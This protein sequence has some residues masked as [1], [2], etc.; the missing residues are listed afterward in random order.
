MDGADTLMG[1]GG[2]DWLEGGAGNDSLNGGDGLDVVLGGLGNDTL[3]G[4][5]GTDVLRGGKGND[6]YIVNNGGGIDVIADP[7][8]G[9]LWIEG[10]GNTPPAGI[11]VADGLWRSQDG[12]VSYT[13]TTADA[14]KTSLVVTFASTGA[15][16][17]GSVVL[18]DW[19]P[20][21]LGINLDSTV[22]TQ[23]GAQIF[24]GDQRAK[25]IGVEVDTDIVPGKPGYRDYKWSATSWAAGG[26]LTE[27]VAAIGFSD[28]IEG[29]ASNDLISGLAGNDAL[30]GQG[31]ND[32]IEG[33][34]GADLIGGGAGSDT[35]LG[36]VGN[37]CILSGAGLTVNRQVNVDDPAWAS[38]DG[39]P[40][41][42]SGA[43]WGITKSPAEV[44]QIYGGDQNHDNSPDIV[45]G[46]AGDDLVAGGYGDDFIDGGLDNDVLFGTG[47]ADVVYGNIGDDHIFGDGTLVPGL[48]NTTPEAEHGSDMLDGG[49]GN[50]K[51]YGGGKGDVLFGGADADM[52]FG[53]DSAGELPGASHGEDYL[54]GGTGNDTLDGGGAGDVLLGG[55]DADVMLGDSPDL[56]ETFHGGDVLEGGAGNDALYGFG[57]DDTLRGGIGNDWIAGE[58]Q[59]SSA[60]SSNF[61]GNDYLDGGDGDDTLVGGNGSDTI[62]GGSGYDHLWGGAGDD[63]YII[64]VE[65]VPSNNTPAVQGGIA[66]R[67][68]FVNLNTTN[69]VPV[70]W[71]ASVDIV[72]TGA[73][74]LS[75]SIAAAT[76]KAYS[77]MANATSSVM[78]TATA[79]P[80]ESINDSAGH[81]TLQING[82][83][84]VSD[85]DNNA[86]LTL[87]I[88]GTASGRLLTLDNA[89]Y[90]RVAD[91]VVDGSTVSVRDW[92]QDKVKTNFEFTTQNTNGTPGPDH[93]LFGAGGNDILYGSGLPADSA[94]AYLANDTLDGGFGNDFIFSYD[95]DDFLIGAEGN[96]SLNGDKGNDS[97]WG[98]DGNDSLIDRAGNNVFNGG[99]GDD[100]IDASVYNSASQGSNTIEFGYGD[101]HDLLRRANI[102][103]TTNNTLALGAG[104]SPSDL[105]VT[106]ERRSYWDDTGTYTSGYVDLRISLRSTG[107]SILIEDFSRQN[108]PYGVG[109]PL[110]GVIF[111]DGLIWDT[112]SLC[113]AIGNGTDFND[114]IFGF[115]WDQSLSGGLGDDALVGA[116]PLG[117]DTLSGGAGKD[118]LSGDGILQGGDGDDHVQGTGSLYG[119]DGNDTV[120]KQSW[121]AF[122]SR[123]SIL[124]GGA[125]NDTI[126]GAAGDTL[127]GGLGDDLLQG[128][129]SGNSNS[130]SFRGGAGVDSIRGYLQNTVYFDR[131]DGLDIFYGMSSGATTDPTTWSHLV[132]GSGVLASDVKARIAGVADLV[133]DLGYGDQVTLEGY[134]DEIATSIGD[135]EF[136][137]G[138]SRLVSSFITS[139]TA[140]ADSMTGTTGDDLIFGV[141]GNDT[142]SGSNGND[143][144][145]GGAGNDSLVGGAGNDTL[146]GGV[147]AD[148]LSGGL[149]DDVYHID[150]QDSVVVENLNEGVDSVYI[151]QSNYFQSTYTLPSNIENLVLT[152]FSGYSYWLAGSGNALNNVIT[153][154]GADNTLLGMAGADTLIGDLGNDTLDGGAGIDS[155]VGGSGDDT[156]VVDSVSDVI[157]ELASDGFDQ[158]Q[159]TASYVLGTEVEGLTLLGTTAINGTGNGLGNTLTGNTAVNVLSGLAGNDT[160]D[161]AGGADTLLGGLGDDT[162]VVDTAGTVITEAMSEGIDTI[163][164]SISLVATADNVENVTLTGAGAINATGNDLANVLQG[165]TFANV[166][167]G[168]RGS[169]YMAG[170]AGNDTFVLNKGDG[171]DTIDAS[172]VLT[173]VDTLSV[174]VLDTELVGLRLGDS[175]QLRIK[176]TTDQITVANYFGASYTDASGSAADGKIDRIQFSNGVVWD[177]AAIQL[178]IDNAASNH[179]PVV[180]GTLPALTANQGRV[181][182]YTVVANVVT[183]PDVGDAIVYSVKMGDGSAV[184]SWLAFDSSTRVLSGTPGAVDV[185]TLN[186]VLWGTDSYGLSVSTPVTMSVVV[187]PNAAP[188]LAAAL[189]DQLALEGQAFSY[190]VSGSAFTDPDVGDSL[191]YTAK[192]ADGT[193]LPAWL[194]FNAASHTFTGTPPVGSSG[195]VSVSVTATDTGS[196]SASDIFDITISSANLNLTGT[197]AADTLTGG[198]G[199]DT[200]SGLAGND[201]LTGQAGNDSLDGGLGNDAMAGGLGD[202]TYVVDATTDVVTENANEG[203]DTVQTS[204][205]LTALAANVENLSLLGTAALNATG[206]A[207]NNVLTGNSAA[208]TL[209]GGA[210]NDTMLGGQGND[211]YVVD[212][213]GDV[214]TENLG[215]GTDTIQASVTLATLAANVENLT[216]TGT[217][218]INGVGN[219]LNNLITGNSAINTLTGGAGDDSL[220]GGAGNDNL[221]GGLGNDVYVVDAAGDVVIEN[222]NEGTDTVQSTVT[223]TA[224]AANAENLTLTGTKAINGT[225]N[226]LNNVLIGNSAI[227]TLTG[228]AGD[229]TLDG[230]AGADKLVGGLGNDTY[231]VDATTDVVTE[232]ANEGTDTIQAKVTLTALANNV[233]NLTLLG[234]AALNATGNTLNNLL[235]GNS[236]VNTLTGNAGDDT[237]V[238][239]LGNDVLVGGAGNDTYRFAIGDGQ[240]SVTENDATAGNQD[241]LEFGAGITA[242]SVTVS[243]VT[244]NLVITAKVGTDKVT[245]TNWYL[246]TAYKVENVRWGDGTTTTA[247]QL[248]AAAAG[249]GLLAVVSPLAS[250]M[251]GIAPVSR[252]KAAY[253]TVQRSL[254]GERGS[255]VDG[256]TEPTLV[257]PAGLLSPALVA[258]HGLN[259]R[260]AQMAENGVLFEDQGSS[261]NANLFDSVTSAAMG[262]GDEPYMVHRGTWAGRAMSQQMRAAQP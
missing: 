195:K 120:R 1:N 46:G 154:N 170:G 78:V 149:G 16:K 235:T 143:A 249:T 135:V 197:A 31:G 37:D 183:D 87:E 76:S 45:D 196:L 28:V 159:A 157:L 104:I 75:Q 52:L 202:D 114:N 258:W 69:T 81:D 85:T 134:F 12:K 71:N 180:S 25:I 215:E 155:L 72:G 176:G 62:L 5:A 190:V 172:D 41:W 150:Q 40:I 4:G 118:S 207:L 57:G 51:L 2:A 36:G 117:N 126:Y 262:G 14:G 123:N 63:L 240:D 210:G 60:A 110:Q 10:Y 166:L 103:T 164:T 248:E 99:A 113:D 251:V 233:E 38:P 102:Y 77:P 30:S 53:D 83:F 32:R 246:G 252:A 214:V 27:S 17:G 59:T 89:Y 15:L 11:K 34:E 7:D 228:A 20:G 19:Q 33:G 148:R 182:S 198:V 66:A 54:D 225:G 91:L 184:P 165:N 137:D 156:Y 82:G 6:V 97:L 224:L 70:G 259:L 80:Y 133:L 219:E 193:A 209:S 49:A 232:N 147:G 119:S 204:V 151:V 217:A 208:N 229:D 42:T 186:F 24:N 61:S 26:N 9:E 187:P 203:A 125:G 256:A 116:S 216:L 237:L 108:D 132:L 13:L 68:V 200:L 145:L 167:S 230:A 153:G 47:G 244:N 236:G 64:D 115:G 255:P 242:S 138:S 250:P 260:L 231:V 22:P 179:A 146:V 161:G 177:Q 130:V 92:V 261:S 98:G 226:A 73:E 221:I 142:I 111:S 84:S 109:S 213:T 245:L 140:G 124:D 205:T 106:R 168:G 105:L 48:A 206:N 175:L 18:N 3:S 192:L 128:D 247:A 58:G 227:N 254:A 23:S 178:A 144:I 257:R 220:N 74:V 29:Y 169:D 67:A 171:Q 129:N 174:A 158:I 112:K 35:I 201:T 223:I 181:F 218:A 191:S 107:D 55:A 199:N 43:T 96:D 100:T 136:S 189:P 86:S 121:G 241:W 131:G 21:S 90:G 253:V 39:Y 88:G 222:L 79:A 50:D 93:Y 139:G 127:I 160:L 8:G 243:K 162:Y 94:F 101:G 56:P 185:G 194:S 239:G 234:T 173:A 163:L 122:G 65:D 188:A 212:A 152:D 95:G 238:G 141:D 44:Y 211:I